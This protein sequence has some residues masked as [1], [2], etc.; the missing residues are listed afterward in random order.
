MKASTCSMPGCSTCGRETTG[1]RARRHEAMH[2]TC[3]HVC[4][5]ARRVTPVHTLT[6][7]CMNV[8]THMYMNPIHMSAHTH[9][10]THT[11]AH[12]HT[13]THTRCTFR[14]AINRLT[15]ACTRAP[16]CTCAHTSIRA[17]THTQ[18]GGAAANQSSLSIIRQFEARGASIYQG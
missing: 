6:H 10:H 14:T 9:T 7:A 11:H 18:P 13:H 1:R 15:H 8:Y 4:V 12:P 5:L 3:V 2:G 16:T 17:S